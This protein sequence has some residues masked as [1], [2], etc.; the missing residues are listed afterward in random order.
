MGS[1][2]S[3]TPSRNVPGSFSECPGMRLAP[4]HPE[5]VHQSP[6][7]VVRCAVRA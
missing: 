7:V 2:G 3:E 4:T 1:V 5:V 6:S